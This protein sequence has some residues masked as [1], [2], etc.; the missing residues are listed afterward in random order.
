MLWYSDIERIPL[1]KGSLS[2]ANTGFLMSTGS[3]RSRTG[4]WRIWSCSRT[5]PGM[6]NGASL[7]I[8]LLGAGST[9]F[10][11][12]LLGDILS[13]PELAEVSISLFDID[14]ERLSTSEIVGRRWL[15]DALGAPPQITATT[16]RRRALEW[17]RLCHRDVPGR[18]LQTRHGDRLRN[19]QKIRP[20]ADHR[21]YAGH[22]RHHARRCA[23]S[24]C[25]WIS[26]GIWKQV[27]PDVTFLQL[28]QPDGDEL[29]GDQ[30]GEQDQ[31]RGA[32]PQ[33]PGYGRAA[34]RGY[35][36]A[37][38]GDQLHLRRHQPHGLL[39][40]LERAGEDPV[41]VHPPGDR[42]EGA[43]P[44]RPGALR[45]L[46]AAGLFCHRIA[47]SISANTCPGLSSA[48]APT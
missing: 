41:P 38:R 36:R 23:P 29:L 2:S 30:P 37:D 28:R 19:P 1:G 48:T 33:R 39:P 12:R 44:R 34:G 24:R 26:A 11:R 27:C 40:A 13:F 6:E 46:R 17:R 14:A 21:R 18:R 7:K 22:R 16:D 4:C 31:D 35:R 8:C 10:A 32:V 3:T 15:T 9:V 45:N 47:A 25:C 42:R 5:P 43:C 20:A